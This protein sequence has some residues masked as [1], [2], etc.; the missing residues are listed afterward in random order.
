M[1][2][3]DKS[4]QDYSNYWFSSSDGHTIEEFNHLLSKESI[5]QLEAEGGAC[6]VYTHFASNFV[7]EEGQLNE[8][9]MANIKYLSSKDGWF[10]PTSTLLDYLLSVKEQHYVSKIYLN[11][12]DFRWIFDR[13]AKKLKY[14]R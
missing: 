4:K 13:I 6:I 5:D 1:P 8:E 3:M 2:Y 9:F 10:V 14:S 12:L 7:N 11:R